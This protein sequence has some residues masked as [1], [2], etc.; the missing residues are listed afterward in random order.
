MSSAAKFQNQDSHNGL[1]IINAG[2]WR[3]ATKSMARAYQI[4][5]F[6]VHHGLL[7]D[8]TESPWTAIEHAA[9]AKWPWVR[10]PGTPKRQPFQRADWDAIWGFKCKSPSEIDQ[11][12]KLLGPH[13]VVTTECRDYATTNNIAIHALSLQQKRRATCCT[14]AAADIYQTT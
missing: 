4:L 6:K 12:R 3:T 1:K 14:G 7:E 5:G 9:E 10:D 2:L 13:I 8:V 11:L